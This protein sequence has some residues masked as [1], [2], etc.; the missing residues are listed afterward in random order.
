MAVSIVDNTKLRSFMYIPGDDGEEGNFY[1]EGKG[2]SEVTYNFDVSLYETHYISDLSKTTIVI[3]QSFNYSI[4]T[5]IVG[6]ETSAGFQVDRFVENI[7]GRKVGKE[8]ETESLLVFLYRKGKQENS[9]YALKYKVSVQPANVAVSGG[10]PLKREYSVSGIG[11]A[12]VGSVVVSPTSNGDITAVF[13][14]DE[15]V[16]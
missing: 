7:M 1:V 3:G 9:F 5:D 14:P 4:S 16:V 11:D 2:A 10:V 12:V 6:D 13:T 8:A 15:E